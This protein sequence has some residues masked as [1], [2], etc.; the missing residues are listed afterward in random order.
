MTQLNEQ[1]DRHTE[2]Q[3]V[4]GGEPTA[5]EMRAWRR[6][7]LFLPDDEATSEEFPRLLV[8]L[9]D[10]VAVQGP[11]SEVLGRLVTNDFLALLD[12][13]NRHIVVLLNSGVTS[14]TE[15]ANILG[16]ANHSAVSKRLAQIR[17]AAEAH[18]DED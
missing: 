13:R 3:M 14:K 11:E 4:E 16:Y 1:T 6:D 17:R 10:T 7:S 12:T 9:T 2:Q 18:F 15:I 5:A 8:E